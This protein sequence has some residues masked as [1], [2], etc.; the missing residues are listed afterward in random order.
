MQSNDLQAMNTCGRAC[1]DALGTYGSD[2]MQP[3]QFKVVSITP[4]GRAESG[5]DSNLQPRQEPGLDCGSWSP[6]AA[7][8]GLSMCV[9]EDVGKYLSTY[10]PY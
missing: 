4:W 8:W 5:E 2:A 7:R 6:P 1:L 3:N 10:L 9:P